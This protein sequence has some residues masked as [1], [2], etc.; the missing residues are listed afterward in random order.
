[1]LRKDGRT[2]ALLYPFVTSFGEG[3]NT[4]Q[5]TMDSYPKNTVKTQSEYYLLFSLPWESLYPLGQDL[6]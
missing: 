6:I 1:M 4:W 2:I 3:I 5:R